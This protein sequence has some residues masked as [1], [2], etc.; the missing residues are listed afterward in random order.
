[1]PNHNPIH[2]SN[3]CRY[4]EPAKI[5]ELLRRNEAFVKVVNRCALEL[6]LAGKL[7]DA[8]VGGARHRSRVWRILDC[9]QR[10]HPLL[11]VV[12]KWMLPE[13]T[14]RY[15]KANGD[16]GEGSTPDI[17]KMTW[18]PAHE[19]DTGG[20][21][22]L[23]G[24]TITALEGGPGQ[25]QKWGEHLSRYGHPNLKT[26][27]NELPE[28]MRR[29]VEFQWAFHHFS[30]TGPYETK[31]HESDYFSMDLLALFKNEETKGAIKE[32]SL[33]AVYQHQTLSSNRVFCF[34][35]NVK[36]TSTQIRSI[37]RIWAD[38]VCESQSKS[39]EEKFGTPIQWDTLLYYEDELKS[40][41]YLF[42]VPE[43]KLEIDEEDLC[44]FYI[45]LVSDDNNLRNKVD[46][47]SLSERREAALAFAFEEIHMGGGIEGQS[48]QWH[49]H[50]H[51]YE[52]Y[53]KEMDSPTSGR[54]HIQRVYPPRKS[55]QVTVQK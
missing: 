51:N 39:R 40:L 16:I 17:S 3:P 31:P 11:E 20:W 29:E 49:H 33:A 24:P 10:A 48:V 14:Y 1:M 23:F 2:H 35:K 54:G 27:W 41:S 9:V 13:T 55:K 12:V 36:M 37:F 22:M 34:P 43:E 52:D 26:V 21:L 30:E 32:N 18:H 38:S 47:L 46:K 5:W 19:I 7:G 50:R 42:G 53:L 6:Q 8:G 44:L 28:L 45:Q 4:G 15:E 25:F